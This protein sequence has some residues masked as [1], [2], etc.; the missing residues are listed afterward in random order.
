M[1]F[2]RTRNSVPCT[3][4]GCPLC[5]AGNQAKQQLM[6][7]DKKTGEQLLLSPELSEKIQSI[8]DKAKEQK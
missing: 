2:W 1:T 8:V 6:A 5:A 7:T 3:G 4:P